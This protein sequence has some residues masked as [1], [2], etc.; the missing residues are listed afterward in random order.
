MSDETK[1][2]TSPVLRIV[3]LVALIFGAMT[4]YSGGMVLFG[5]EEARIKAGAYLPYVV[6]FN[7]LAGFFYIGAGIG[8]W[9]AKRW[10]ARLGA[11]IAVATLA[12]FVVFLV[13]ISLGAAYETRTLA[14]LIF[15]TG[16]WVILTALAWKRA[17][18]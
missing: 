18:A 8:L 17:Q 4:L 5:P 7:F 10:G 1:P 12:V 13:H 16:V 14:A 3:A 6:W 15:R 11:G 2:V 9:R